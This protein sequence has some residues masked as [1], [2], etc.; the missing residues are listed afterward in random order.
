[1]DGLHDP[2]P[3]VHER[4]R[5]DV[6]SCSL[7]RNNEWFS[8][9][10]TVPSNN[11][12]PFNPTCCGA[13][14]LEK[15]S[16]DEDPF[17][18]AAKRIEGENKG[19]CL[20]KIR[21]LRCAPCSPYQSTVSDSRSYTG[22]FRVCY[23]FCQ[24]LWESCKGNQLD[25][26]QLEG[27]YD[28][29]ADQFCSELF[30]DLQGNL[31]ILPSLHQGPAGSC[32]TDSLKEC[33]EESLHGYYTACDEA[34][35]KRS[36]VYAFKDR[37]CSGGFPLPSPVNGLDCYQECLPGE[38]LPPAGR[39]CV[40]CP[41]GSFS[42]GGGY[43]FDQWKSLPVEF[44]WE[45][46][47]EST[48][49][50]NPDQGERIANCTAWETEGTYLQ[51][52]EALE[53][54]QNAVLALKTF[55]VQDG[56][57]RFVFKVDAEPRYDGLR[58]AIDGETVMTYFS[59][60]GVFVEKNYSLTAGFHLLKW[61]FFKD[62]SDSEGSDQAFIRSIE[63]LGVKWADS[64]CRPCTLG[65]FSGVGES[66]CSPCSQDTFAGSYGL[67][68]CV[69]CPASQF[70][71]EGASECYDRPECQ[72]VD[73]TL[74]YS[75]C[76]EDQTRNEV[77]SYLHPIICNSSNFTLPEGTKNVPC[78]DCNPGQYRQGSSC[79]TCPSGTVSDQGKTQCTPCKAGTF[80]RKSIFYTQFDSLEDLV[81]EN[82]NVTTF[83]QGDCATSKGFRLLSE[84]MDSGVG[85]GPLV[86]VFLQIDTVLE[87][88]GEALFNVSVI[89]YGECRV[90]LVS[91]DQ[92][93]LSEPYRNKES[94]YE[95]LK[96]PLAPGA[97]QIQIIFSK[98]VSNLDANRTS[99]LIVHDFLVTGVASGG[100]KEC[101][102]CPDG[103]YS[104]ESSFNCIPCPPGY[105]S[106][107]GDPTCTLCPERTFSKTNGTKQCTP[108]GEGTEALDDRTDCDYHGC[109]YSPRQD[110]V[111][112]LSPLIENRTD[113]YGPIWDV[114][115]HSFFLNPCRRDHPNRS[116]IGQDGNPMLTH[117][118]QFMPGTGYSY[119]LG[120]VMGF[121]P[122][123][124]QSAAADPNDPARSGLVMKF[125]EGSA[126]CRDKG[127]SAFPRTTNIYFICD[128]SAGIGYPEAI[129][130]VEYSPCKYQFAWKSLY[131]CP[132]CTLD[133]YDLVAGD[134]EQTIANVTYVPKSFPNRCH[135]GLPLP[136]PET[137]SCTTITKNCS[138]GTYFPLNP[139]PKTDCVETEPGF[140]TVGGGFVVD[141]WDS[142]L[143]S[144]YNAEK[145][146]WTLQGELIRSGVDDTALIFDVDLVQAGYVKFS[147]KVV[148]EGIRSVDAKGGFYFYIDGN[149][150][151]LTSV[152]TTKYSYIPARY[153]LPRGQHQ[154]E[155][156]FIGG[157]EPTNVTRGYYTVIDKIEVSGT[158]FAT[159]QQIPCR[160]G[161][162]QD[163][164]GQGSCKICPENTKSSSG[165]AECYNCT[166]GSY[167]LKGSSDCKLQERCQMRDYSLSYSSCKKKKM[168]KIYQPL[169]PKTCFDEDSLF[170]EHSGNGATVAC[171]SCPDGFFMNGDGVCVGC[172]KGQ[173]MKKG[174]CNAVPAGHYA[175]KEITYF[176]SDLSYLQPHLP[177]GD[178]PP[179]FSTYCS[180]HCGSPG[181]RL[182]NRTVDSGSHSVQNEVDSVLVL[183][184]NI[185]HRGSIS[186][187]YMVSSSL[188][189]DD[190]AEDNNL[191][192]FEF[193]IGGMIPSTTIFYHN[194]E[195]HVMTTPAFELS[196]GEFEFKWVFHQPLLTN[197]Q[198]RVFVSDVKIVGSEEGAPVDVG[199]CAP[200]YYS[201]E[202]SKDGCQP[203]EPGKASGKAA[204]NCFECAED[205]YSNTFGSASCTACPP[206][207]VPNADHTDCDLNGCAFTTE[208]GTTF[209]VSSLDRL[210]VLRQD[211]QE[212]QM[213]ICNRLEQESL[214]FD[215]HK[216]AIEKTNVCMVDLNL[217]VG[218]DIGSVLSVLDYDWEG[219]PQLKLMYTAGACAHGLDKLEQTEVSFK[220]DPSQIDYVDPKIKSLGPC[221]Y[222]LE[223]KHIA[224][225]R[226]CDELDYEVNFE[227]CVDGKQ[228]IVGVRMNDCNGPE[229]VEMS[230]RKCSTSLPLS[231]P[232]ILI[233]CSLFLI[234]L[235]AMV[236]LL[237]RNYKMADRYKMLINSSSMDGGPEHG[238]K[239]EED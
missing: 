171:L 159:R 178:I 24:S 162:Y 141:R 93:S 132:L 26:L 94:K 204:A 23:D 17:S 92:N 164:P 146:S 220:C 169:E 202:G 100:A 53:D 55:L 187:S 63:V 233:G 110:L 182:V 16:Q 113:L 71:Y 127:I 114:T 89:C 3:V 222:S 59:N 69:D 123:E 232:L 192:G 161:F 158:H 147:Y 212:I 67:P 106:V 25:G 97:Q 224:G 8:S 206:P 76:Q 188:R 135:D 36:F 221:H 145:S 166:D 41:G 215:E 142:T 14:W 84:D 79:L 1:L 117:A 167:S 131:A 185:V 7:S 60:A 50:Y 118:C 15:V 226:V 104:E 208:G 105:Y 5:R 129:R 207:L 29:A 140:F 11:L 177:T 228:A 168:T 49:G 175:Q 39:S 203:C 73:Y 27:Q 33:T 124:N 31:T 70:S 172:P 150:P 216:V 103:Y 52:S 160:A 151:S 108:C 193:F 156:R 81:T 4:E 211:G 198:K 157:S 20:S 237:I 149:A 90:R 148:A 121:M 225:C 197:R 174:K 200:G 199:K 186:F 154:L 195:D 56:L 119:D 235:F 183:N 134:C 122:F 43:S 66:R 101:T 22:F 28:G 136:G 196:P 115:N 85:H 65:T 137:V 214:C 75:A 58:F 10:P 54:K 217:N 230:H 13:E 21:K 30:K 96:L 6:L 78:A 87:D 42:V 74:S 72:S 2:I 205:E 99:R 130:S 77:Y 98:L 32:Y 40:S 19:N 9:Q 83:C 179:P 128:P 126:G 184:V 190:E 86:D 229:F 236:I 219:L 155:W 139:D 62:S 38:Y 88:A 223:W 209:N 61:Y 152:T 48:N 111:Y 12:C 51:V 191:P 44:D 210:V 18:I 201:V 116:C 138:A 125:T 180:G 37:D 176:A 68:Q 165:Q 170:L 181:W 143:P 163:E 189:S 133:D 239:L 80:A 231:L 45:N 95:L 82:S 107:G 112:D 57:V 238:E 35:K 109:V 153:E 194:E 102:T 120:N 91:V 227:K 213:R 34:T 144:E 173:Y 218:R 47:C 234:L 64:S 46:Y